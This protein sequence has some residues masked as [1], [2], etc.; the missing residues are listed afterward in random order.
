M[1]K[2]QGFKSIAGSVTAP[3]GFKAAAVFCDIKRIGTGKGS[4]KG[5]Q[6]RSRHHCFGCARGRRGDVHD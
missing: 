5:T 2:G 3:Q 6:A 1:A 4:N